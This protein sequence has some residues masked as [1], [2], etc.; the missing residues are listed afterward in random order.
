MTNLI[1]PGEDAAINRKLQKC[2]EVYAR[3][4]KGGLIE[5]VLKLFIEVRRLSIAVD[6]KD[7]QLKRLRNEEM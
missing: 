5:M 3:K 2:H 1:K 6:L 7:E 4:G